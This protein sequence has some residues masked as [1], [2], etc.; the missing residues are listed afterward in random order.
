MFE[1][2]IL[3]LIGCM[4]MIVRLNLNKR[5]NYEI[6]TLTHPQAPHAPS[7]NTNSLA[8]DFLNLSISNT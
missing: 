6:K 3:I 8:K 4:N 1:W 5:I 7:T 2:V